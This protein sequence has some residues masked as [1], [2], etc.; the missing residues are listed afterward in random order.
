MKKTNVV[1]TCASSECRQGSQYREKVISESGLEFLISSYP[2]SLTSPHLQCEVARI[3][4]YCLIYLYL[5]YMQLSLFRL[6][7]ATLYEN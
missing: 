3:Q 4:G 2:F 5:F 6:K 7:V 1:L